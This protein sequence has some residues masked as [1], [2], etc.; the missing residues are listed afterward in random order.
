MTRPE[1]LLIILLAIGIIAV[2]INWNGIK[3]G[4]VKGWKY[5]S[6]EKWYDSP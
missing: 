4:F 6:I 3:E 1:K 2:A 5:F